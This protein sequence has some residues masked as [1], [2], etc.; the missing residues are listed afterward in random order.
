MKTRLVLKQ[1]L[2]YRTSLMLIPCTSSFILRAPLSKSETHIYANICTSSPNIS[3]YPNQ[4]II[5]YS[6]P[7][8]SVWL[9]SRE[10]VDDICWLGQG[11]CERC[12]KYL[13]PVII[14]S[15]PRESKANLTVGRLVTH[16]FWRRA[17]DTHIHA[18]RHTAVSA[19]LRKHWKMFCQTLTLLADALAPISL[20]LAK[21]NRASILAG[22]LR[23]SSWRNSP[24]MGM[25]QL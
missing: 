20:H 21:G 1:L 4:F 16:Q 2:R 8:R 13:V 9:L 3:S 12:K 7:P 6:I 24:A 17:Q 14:G 18:Q 23:E 15:E 11:I 22:M 10:I 19:G 5:S 25:R